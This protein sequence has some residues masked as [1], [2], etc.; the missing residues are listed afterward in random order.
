MQ[1]EVPESAVAARATEHWDGPQSLAEAPD[2][3]SFGVASTEVEVRQ[4]NPDE[5]S[6]SEVS[7]APQPL[8]F[9][10][11]SDGSDV[12]PTVDQNSPA[13]IVLGNQGQ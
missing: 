5:A 10:N 2:R 13:R 3:S 11:R 6:V 9:K 1:N 8:V 12:A 4:A 7:A